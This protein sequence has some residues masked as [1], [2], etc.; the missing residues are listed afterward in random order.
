MGI[1][2]E[3]ATNIPT[4]IQLTVNAL[5]GIEGVDHMFLL[6]MDKQHESLFVRIEKTKLHESFL[7]KSLPIKLEE[8]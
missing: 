8:I 6:M 4:L 1:K 3:T 5:Y 2:I 7:N